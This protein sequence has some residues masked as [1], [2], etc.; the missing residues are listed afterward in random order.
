MGDGPR[1]LEEELMAGVED[2]GR[3]PACGRSYPDSLAEH[4]LGAKHWKAV[5]YASWKAVGDRRAGAG[6][7][8]WQ[9]WERGDG[10]MI[11]F[12]HWTGRCEVVGQSSP[13]LLRLPPRPPGLPPA[14][15]LPSPSLSR[16]D[17]A[18][19]AWGIE[20]RRPSPSPGWGSQ[21]AGGGGLSGYRKKQF[22]EAQPGPL[23]RD[24]LK[25][26]S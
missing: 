8:V 4:L 26:T 15:P 17:G 9:C 21:P 12:D 13:A 10:T 22:S 24:L 20:P 16:T 2:W 18:E 25:G 19:S 5:R 3:C 7:G 14:P 11:R 6:F 23:R 1:M